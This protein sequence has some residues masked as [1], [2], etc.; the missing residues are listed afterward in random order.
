M[1]LNAADGNAFLKIWKESLQERLH[2]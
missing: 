1:Q 2:A